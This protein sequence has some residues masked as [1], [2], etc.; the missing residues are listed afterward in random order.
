MNAGWTAGFWGRMAA[1]C[2]A[3][4]A[5]LAAAPSPAQSFDELT[6]ARDAV[7]ASA[8][9]A[10]AQLRR[11]TALLEA[12]DLVG[13]KAAFDAALRARANWVDALWGLARI[14]MAEG[15]YEESRNACRR[16]IS[17]AGDAAAD[18]HVCM[19]QAYLVWRRSS[20]AIDEFNKALAAQ[21]DN[22]RALCG[23]GDAHARANELDQ[24][25][26]SYR[27][28][29]ASDA[30]L[31]EAHLGL[32]TM[33]E[34]KGD[35]AGAIAE[36]KTALGVRSW[37]ADAQYNLGRLLTDPGEA[38]PHLA[39]AVA[40][41]PSFTDAQMEY[42]KKLAAAGRWT[43]ALAPLRTAAAQLPNVAQ[44]NELLGIA[45]WKNGE[46]AEAETHL[47][48][49]IQ[50]VPNSARANEALGEVLVAGG[51][52]E[53][54]LA[55]LE[56]ASNLDATNYGLAMRI[57]QVLRGQGRNTL[58][59]GWLDKALKIKAD[60]SAAQVMYGDI[61]FEQGR[62]AE[63]RPHYEAALAGDGAGI[64]RAAIT[65]RLSQLQNLAPQTTP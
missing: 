50:G 31:L 12:R 29:I 46:L 34:R 11:G 21:A 4:A 28:A 15:N 6:Q 63:S 52:I 41:R 14:R 3:G 16:V 47:R 37:S 57:A 64:D 45:L 53:D 49:A 40:I 56:T 48:A 5:L 62:Y 61:L 24:A 42:G 25:I 44:M 58:A 1:L 32:A 33:L 51:R 17:A 59:T 13:A 36:L 30:G 23:I 27:K 39:L 19:G 9:D 8:T 35:T 20:L 22:A 2:V 38:I 18:G 10:A 7:A 65:A 60:L 43:E 26:D 55:L 54:G